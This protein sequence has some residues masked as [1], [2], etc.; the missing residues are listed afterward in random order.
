MNVVKRLTKQ[1][2]LELW[3]QKTGEYRQYNTSNCYG[4]INVLKLLVKD[5]RQGGI[6]DDA[7]VFK[8]FVAGRRDVLLYVLL[9]THGF[10]CGS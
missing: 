2:S 5:L 4:V 10:Y 6:F 3:E 7:S 1:W 8:F 9:D